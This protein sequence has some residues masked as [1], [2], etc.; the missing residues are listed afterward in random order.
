M[1]AGRQMICANER[2]DH[3]FSCYLLDAH[4]GL[5]TAFVQ[6]VAVVS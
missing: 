1:P 6:R 2:H 5:C 3:L 4:D